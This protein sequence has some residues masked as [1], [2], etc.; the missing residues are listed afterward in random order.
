MSTCYCG[1]RYCDFMD[2]ERGSL[3]TD[4]YTSFDMS[5]N[6]KRPFRMH[7]LEYQKEKFAAEYD[8]LNKQLGFSIESDNLTLEGVGCKE[9]KEKKRL[10]QVIAEFYLGEIVSNKVNFKRSDY[11][12]ILLFK[13]ILRE[14]EEDDSLW[15]RRTLSHV[16]LGFVETVEA[17]SELLEF[18]MIALFGGELR[19]HQGGQEYFEITDWTDSEGCSVY[20]RGEFY[21]M[22]MDWFNRNKNHQTEMLKMSHKMLG[23][24]DSD[25]F[26]GEAWQQVPELIMQK[27]K[28]AL[29]PDAFE[30]HKMFIDRAFSIQHNNGCLFDK[31]WSSDLV[32]STLNAH[33]NGE[34][35]HLAEFTS[36]VD[37]WKTYI[38][39]L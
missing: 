30:N 2:D 3:T 13:N 36:D 27:R 20:D 37:A 29:G 31:V 22:W 35:K 9:L 28:G 16:F 26:G 19:H 11:E 15:N 8:R 38:G 39:A 7:D 34:I 14:Q 12:S 25:S 21:S 5:P 1:D 18:V 17:L 32:M 24:F 10:S 4:G 23:E 33:A 6:L